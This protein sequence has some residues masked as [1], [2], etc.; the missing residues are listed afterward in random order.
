VNRFLKKG[1]VGMKKVLWIIPVAALA[2][3]VQADV[4][5]A[6]QAQGK[7]KEK[8]VEKEIT[9]KTGA[10]AILK[11]IDLEE[12]KGKEVKKGDNIE[13]HYTGTLESG[14]K[15]DS[16]R[17]RGQPFPV[18]IGKGMVIVGW[19]EGIPG[20]KEGGKRKLIIPA[21][22]AYGDRD[23]GGGLIP[24]GSTLIFEV[25]VLKVK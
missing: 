4:G 7:G 21:A 16:S 6:R 22:L 18:T 3:L 20:M 1:Q 25:E 14:K 15:F 10:K 13:V 19:D 12:G 11:Y 9:T 17:E 8:V 5:S 23:V 24:A 2:L